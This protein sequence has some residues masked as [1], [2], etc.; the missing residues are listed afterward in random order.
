[1]DQF[2]KLPEEIQIAIQKARHRM[3]ETMGNNMDLYGITQSIGHLYGMMYFSYA[4][5]TLDEMGEKMGMSKTS[6]STGMRTL[7]DLKMVNKVWNKGSRKDLYTTEPDWYQNL[8]DYF[9]LRWRKSME[10]NVS[11][12]H[13][14][15][16]EL[17]HIMEQYKDDQD[18]VA[19]IEADLK[20]MKHALSYYK[21]L[22]TFIRSF[23]TDEIFKYFPKDDE[24][25]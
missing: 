24:T 8:S 25:N 15:V 10:S 7:I 1:M 16:S 13:K 20:K 3:I 14:A 19:I 6:M 21:W 23:E 11:Q 18:A 17:T 9:S 22:D 4:P 12:I 5:V 2:E